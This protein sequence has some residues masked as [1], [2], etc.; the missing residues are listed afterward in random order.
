MIIPDANVLV[1]AYDT[2]SPFHEKSKLW[3]ESEING[4]GS[5]G[6]PWAVTIA[7]LRVITHPRVFMHPI[8]IQEAIAIVQSWYKQP[9]VVPLDPGSRHLVLLV[10]LLEQIQI[11][12]KLVHDAHLAALAREYR[13]Q[14]VSY[15]RDFERFS[16]VSIRSP[17]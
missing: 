17:G 16:G 13:A 7:F 4:G 5:I 1:Y 8:P 11:G 14:I 6:I 2:S 15:D 9:S 12:G 3:W 10:E